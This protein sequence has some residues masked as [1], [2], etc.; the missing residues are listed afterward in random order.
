[1]VR[2]INDLQR[3]HRNTAKLLDILERELAAYD[4]AEQ[5]DYEILAALADYLGGY[6]AVHH[7]PLEDAIFRRLQ[8]ADPDGAT[9]V[10]DQMAEHDILAGLTG[11]F[12]E[13]VDSIVKEMEVPRSALHDS[14]TELLTFYRHHMAMEDSVFFPTAVEK[15][16]EED[17]QAIQAEVDARSSEALDKSREASF[18]RL[19]NQILEWEDA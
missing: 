8:Q 1:M 11:Q 13:T 14:A 16:S 18:E 9:K 3:D 7:H 4:R 5:P 15:L 19:R 2:I 12:A 17:W 6:A 10:G